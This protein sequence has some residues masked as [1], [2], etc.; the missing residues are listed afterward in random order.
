MATFN[1]Q[2]FKMAQ[3]WLP[4]QDKGRES[5]KERYTEVVVSVLVDLNHGPTLPS[6]NHC[7]FTC[8]S[9]RTSVLQ[10]FSACEAIP[11][12]CLEALK[13]HFLIQTNSCTFF[14]G[15]CFYSGFLLLHFQQSTEESEI[16]LPY[17]TERNKLRLISL[18]FLFHTRLRG[19]NSQTSIP[20]RKLNR[21]AILFLSLVHHHH[22][23]LP[24]HY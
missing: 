14:S 5:R 22:F 20:V 15:D 2:H 8:S 17:M 21:C 6:C 19:I 7:I 11:N 9:F 10:S 16:S 24:S 1:G 13:V 3:K 18:R 23:D 4:Y 12:L